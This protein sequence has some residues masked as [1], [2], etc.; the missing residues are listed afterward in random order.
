MNHSPTYGLEGN[1]FGV[2]IFLAERIRTASGTHLIGDVAN[3]LV[4][5]GHRGQYSSG[6]N[7]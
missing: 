1:L 6:G 4:L 3:E 5:H 7:L 2:K